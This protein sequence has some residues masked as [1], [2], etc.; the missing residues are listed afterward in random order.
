MKLSEI[1]GEKA[2]EVIAEIIEPATEILN[3]PKVKLAARS[4]NIASAASIALKNHP[5]AVLHLLAALDGED[6]ET[7]N[8]SLVEIP[9]KLLELFND[10]DL[11]SLFTSSDQTEAAES[12]GPQSENTED[13]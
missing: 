1:K 13:R 12:P 5:K 2:I 3:D 6:P 8:P 9:K 10:P 4:K 7:Y 11:A